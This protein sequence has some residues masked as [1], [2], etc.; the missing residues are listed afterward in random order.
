VA[1]TETWAASRKWLR[2]NGGLPVTEHTGAEI[3]GSPAAFPRSLL[4]G[5]H[6]DSVPNGDCDGCLSVLASVEILQADFRGG[7]PPVTV[8]LVDYGPTTKKA[9][10]IKSL[11]SS[12][13]FSIL[14]WTGAGTDGQGWNFPARDAIA[15]FG[16][17]LNV[18]RAV[19]E[20]RRNYLECTSS[21]AGVVMWLPLGIVLSAP[22]GGASRGH[23][24]AT[25]P[26][27][28]A[29]DEPAEETLSSPRCEDG[30][31]SL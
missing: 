18:K 27:T 21:G 4:I 5:G 3:C 28:Q 20:K 13:A 30:F 26:R 8:K 29:T 11:F 16:I 2:Q 22:A 31:R 1:F 6:I 24:P 14:I 23:L 10:F 25:R 9:R 15:Q 19:T 7:V 12:S 17:D